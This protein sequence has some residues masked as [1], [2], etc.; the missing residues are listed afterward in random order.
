LSRNRFKKV[1][2][3][4]ERNRHYDIFDL[5]ADGFLMVKGFITAGEL[6]EAR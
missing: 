4:Y 2:S 3:E 1:L 6:E 5:L